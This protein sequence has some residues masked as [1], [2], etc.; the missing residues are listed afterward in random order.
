[1]TFI[2]DRRCY[3]CGESGHLAALCPAKADKAPTEWTMSTRPPWCGQCEQRARLVDCADHVV[4][5]RD[6]W[7]W[8]ERRTNR[9]QPLTQHTRCGGCGDVIYSWD[10]A[11]CGKHQELG[12]DRTGRRASAEHVRIEPVKRLATPDQALQQA[13]ES[14]RDRRADFYEPA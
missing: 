11:P 3:S 14:R 8:P 5:C 4:R 13:E 2:D 12:I 10:A 6:C 9:G 1:V 7:A